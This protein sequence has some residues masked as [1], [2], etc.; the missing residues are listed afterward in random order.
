M[1]ALAMI[2]TATPTA[3]RDG[4]V[5]RI[6]YLGSGSPAASGRWLAAF[7][8]RLRKLGY[9]DGENTALV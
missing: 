8:D 3:A 9:V 2:V 5:Y 1:A 7:R 4:R 6:G